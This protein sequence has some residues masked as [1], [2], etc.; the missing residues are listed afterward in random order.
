[1]CILDST[2]SAAILPDTRNRRGSAR[3]TASRLA[4]HTGRDEA[5]AKN[6]SARFTLEAE[7]NTNTVNDCISK[8]QCMRT[9]SAEV[10]H[11]DVVNNQAIT[12]AS[13]ALLSFL[14]I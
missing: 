9:T 3:R 11:F 14:A 2:E 5:L 6:S 4:T 1:M 7:H 10:G 12:T 13:A 8:R